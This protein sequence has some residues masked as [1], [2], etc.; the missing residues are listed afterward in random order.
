MLRPK[1]SVTV[2]PVD[3]IPLAPEIV[4]WTPSEAYLDDPQA[5]RENLDTWK[6][7]GRDNLVRQVDFA[8]EY[9]TE[10]DMGT[11]VS[12]WVPNWTILQLV[13][14]WLVSLQ[15]SHLIHLAPIEPSASM[16]ILSASSCF[17]AT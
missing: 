5:F 6:E 17:Y 13:F 3:S 12:I 10:I 4:W 1:N 9:T 14:S 16:E 8:N 15:L 11:E 7:V 2:A